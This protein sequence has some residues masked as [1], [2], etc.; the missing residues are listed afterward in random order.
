MVSGGQYRSS[1][2]PW[3]PSSLGGHPESRRG[4][5][6]RRDVAVGPHHR[7]VRPHQCGRSLAVCEP[8]VQ[9]R[10]GLPPRA[11]R[12]R[13]PPARARC[14][15]E[16]GT[17]VTSTNPPRVTSSYRL[18]SVRS[19]FGHSRPL[20]DLRSPRRIHQCGPAQR[21]CLAV[22]EAVAQAGDPV[23]P[24]GDGPAEQVTG[25]AALGHG[26]ADELGQPDEGPGVRFALHLVG[27]EHR[28]GQ[29]AGRGRRRSSS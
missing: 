29:V 1:R 18:P 27:V 22:E 25:P 9:G 20:R 15:G 19:A 12:S 3:R 28:L 2:S 14:W 5:A 24:W 26:D 23:Q 7:E 10:A 13:G 21:W 6:E 11:P 4:F 8:L 16:S 17:P